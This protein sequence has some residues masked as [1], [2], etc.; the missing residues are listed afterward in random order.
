MHFLQAHNMS[1]PA[2][3]EIVS[4][5]F[6]LPALTAALIHTQCVCTLCSMFYAMIACIATAVHAATAVSHLVAQSIVSLEHLVQ[7]FKLAK[8]LQAIVLAAHIHE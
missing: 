5:S 4:C 6:C 3:S 1:W 2:D 7:A 8:Q